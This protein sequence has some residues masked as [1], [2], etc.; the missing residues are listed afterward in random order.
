M[1]LAKRYAE[2]SESEIVE[3]QLK[4]LNSCWRNAVVQ[5]PFYAD[6]AASLS[7]SE[8]FK[9]LEDFAELVT[10][11]NRSDLART[12]LR[13]TARFDLVRMTGGST[14]QPLHI[15]VLRSELAHAKEVIQI[16]RH[17]LGLPP[18]AAG[19]L[20]W[21]HS[22]LLGRGLRGAISRL[23]RSIRDALLGYLRISAYDLT[24]D[25]IEAAWQAMIKYKPDFVL[26]YSRVLDAM[27]R[28][29]L[30]TGG[31]RLQSARVI[32]ATAESLPFDDSVSVIESAF[33]APLRMEYG[34]V[35][36]GPIAYSHTP[37]G[38]RVFWWK[39]FLEEASHE[40]GKR[41][42]L[43]TALYPR[44]TPLFRYRLGDLIDLPLIFADSSISVIG[45]RQLYGRAN[46][47]VR[48]PSGRTLHSETA[49]HLFR[50]CP[51]I[52]HYQFWCHPNKVEAVYVAA[53]ELQ[54]HEQAELRRVAAAIDPE[55]GQVIELHHIE[56]YELKQA[57]SGKLPFVVVCA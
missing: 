45:F 34:T 55:L 39:Y 25:A 51:G 53:Q 12:D 8:G 27:A 2:T 37:K 3:L 41:E 30:R 57:R 52:I 54:E 28:H 16:G 29:R 4:M 21:G 36:T 48:L 47:P 49:S 1:Q 50:A 18:A 9:S 24:P 17:W 31:A 11:T 22:H 14:G 23:D 20:I 32:I 6:L 33:N 5:I 40:S 13:S 56:L 10:P 19:T 46:H 15:R 35:E 38:Y 7:R 43:L 26:G 42:I 44:A